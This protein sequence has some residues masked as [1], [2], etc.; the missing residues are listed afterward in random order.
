MLKVVIVGANGKVGR[1]LLNKI[2]SA[3]PTHFDKPLAI[4]RTKD[5][6]DYFTEQ[7]QD[8][9]NVSLTSIEDST[10]DDIAKK[11]SGYDAVVFTA[12]AG[13]KGVERIFTVD[14]DGCCKTIEACGKAGVQRFILVSAIHAED[15]EKWYHTALR[16]YYIAK[17]AAEHE[18][19]WSNLDYTIL[20]PGSLGLE[21]GTG[22]L[23]PAI[24]IESKKDSYYQIQRE[25]LA[26]FIV[27][28]LLNP[29]K[30]IR[31]TIPLANGDEPISEFIDKL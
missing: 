21:K 19:K 15:R 31:K 23:C 8:K 26:T 16:N 11:I 9:I 25:D 17:R 27:A 18:L 4:V 7:F 20:Q 1:L 6:V 22:K 5:Q 30:T 29:S 12:G 28:S 13:G 2:I 10:V 24:D 14:L 3:S